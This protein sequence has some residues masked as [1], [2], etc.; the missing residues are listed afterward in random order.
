ML[1]DKS[2][3][4][5]NGFIS[6]NIKDID[7]SL[8][9]QLYINFKNKSFLDKSLMLRYDGS[10]KLPKNSKIK[11]DIN[12]YFNK[13]LTKF[14]LKNN[15]EINT[16]I[17]IDNK[18]DCIR[19]SLVLCGEY[20]NL[21]KFEK[22]LNRFK[23]HVS[24]CWY[25]IPAIENT[26]IKEI[27]SDIYLKTIWDLYSTD[28]INHSV[29]HRNVISNGTELSL[30]TKNN[31]IE[32]HQDGYNENRLCV[33]LIYLN[34]DYQIGYGGELIVGESTIIKPEF[35]NIVILDFT[36]NNVNHEVLRVIDDNFKRFAFI[37]FFYK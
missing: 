3:L 14:N 32:L 13:I 1:F 10:V 15:S 16:N 8:Y 36:K 30:Y 6:F 4:L 29:Y 24:Q 7:E 19:L 26:K 2:K 5:Q 18:D 20:E 31:F 35:G 22:I 28:I 33:V 11:D 27:L 17:W 21:K 12:Y 37:K 34:D 23:H 25:F 9:Q